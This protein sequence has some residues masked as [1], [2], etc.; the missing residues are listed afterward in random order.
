MFDFEFGQKSYQRQ[1]LPRPW[2]ML[3]RD[4]VEAMRG[5]RLD[6]FALSANGPAERGVQGGDAFW[7]WYPALKRWAIFGRPFGTGRAAPAGN[8]EVVAN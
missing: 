6:S 3:W 8:L 2:Q 7:G 5:A 4:K 1:S